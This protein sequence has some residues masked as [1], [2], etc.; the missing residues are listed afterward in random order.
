MNHWHLHL[1]DVNINCALVSALRHQFFWCYFYFNN[2]SS[3]SDDEFIFTFHPNVWCCETNPVWIKRCLSPGTSIRCLCVILT[4]PTSAGRVTDSNLERLQKTVWL[5]SGAGY[6]HSHSVVGYCNEKGYL[7]Y[8]ACIS[9]QN[10]TGHMASCDMQDDICLTVVG[11]SEIGRSL[12]L[13]C[14]QAPGGAV[15]GERS[16]FLKANQNFIIIIYVS[17]SC[18]ISL[19][20]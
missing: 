9:Y 13:L 4:P 6:W 18:N 8:P 19:I 12:L 7:H 2:S 14:L 20:V 3:C 11:A 17:K 10:V 15:S 1:Q 5:V 16:F